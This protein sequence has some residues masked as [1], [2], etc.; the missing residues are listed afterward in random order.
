MIEGIS[1]KNNNSQVT[2]EEQNSSIK[3]GLKN[4]A[5]GDK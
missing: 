1:N 5:K 2:S 4:I 3:E